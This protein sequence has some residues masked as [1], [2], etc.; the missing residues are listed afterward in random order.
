M[1]RNILRKFSVTLQRCLAILSWFRRYL[2]RIPSIPHDGK[3]NE[4]A[5]KGCGGIGADGDGGDDGERSSVSFDT[6]LGSTP[7]TTCPGVSTLSREAGSSSS[8]SSVVDNINS[9]R[10]SVVVQA[11]HE[12]RAPMWPTKWKY[13]VCLLPAAPLDSSKSTVAA[14]EFLSKYQPV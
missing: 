2:P 9:S 7:R 10:I 3:G 8:S 13:D 12:A 5:S 4:K 6:I 11:T 1:L 14:L